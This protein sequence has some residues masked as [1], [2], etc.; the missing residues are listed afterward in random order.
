M[1]WIK[2]MKTALPKVSICIPCHRS[3]EFMRRLLMSISDQ[4][5]PNIEVI[6]SDDSQ[7][8]AIGKEIDGFGLDIKYFKNHTPL[9]S[10]G[11]WNHAISHATGEYFM[12]V[13]EDDW[14]RG[15]DSVSCFVKAFDEETDFVFCNNI[16]S[17]GSNY[18]KLSPNV[19]P[20]LSKH[21]H[22]LVVCNVI[23]PP[24]NVMLRSKLKPVK[25]QDGM[26]WLVDVEYYYRLISTGFR[27]K[28]I[29][30]DL[31]VVGIHAAQSSNHSRATKEVLVREN[32]AMLSTTGI[33]GVE[34]Y[35][36]YWRFCR[37]LKFSDSHY[38]INHI[39][40][41]QKPFGKL[42]RLGIVSKI[43]M[44]VSYL[45]REQTKTLRKVY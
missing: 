11:N 20:D 6:V 25:Y 12:L 19:Y 16:A 9:K 43:V 3:L 13:H 28:H 37:R 21:P 23:G 45:F 5:Y 44:A 2:K 4:D 38:L 40:A 31:M 8:G 1:N 7:S 41:W 36:Y 32:L 27:F 30:K 26:V 15:K 34:H 18:F 10:P 17:E 35:D 24:C 29:P 39:Q 14:F 33:R 22:S 42:L